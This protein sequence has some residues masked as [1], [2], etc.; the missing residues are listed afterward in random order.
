MNDTQQTSPHRR[1]KEL[2]AIPERQ[3]T[4]AQWDELHE[5][6]IS[7]AP[8]NREDAPRQGAPRPMPTAVPDGR[9]RPGGDRSQRPMRRPRK[10]PPGGNAP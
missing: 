8:G 1:L 3:R 9:Q 6:E 10:K 2:L 4:D 5:L 7:L